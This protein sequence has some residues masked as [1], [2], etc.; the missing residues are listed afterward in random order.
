MI[1]TLTAI[2]Q[3]AGISMELP[4]VVCFVKCE[5]DMQYLRPMFRDIFDELGVEVEAEGPLHLRTPS[6]LIR[7]LPMGDCVLQRATSRQQL[8]GIDPV[9]IHDLRDYV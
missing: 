7:F 6:C 3:V 2:R 9:A 5:R 8:R 1:Q 4:G